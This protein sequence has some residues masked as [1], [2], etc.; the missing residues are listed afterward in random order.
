MAIKPPYPYVGGKRR[1]LNVI[2]ENIP[3]HFGNYYEPFLGAGA[4]AIHTME[5]YPDRHY[6]LS[7]YNPHIPPTWLALQHDIDEV[8]E[9]LRE[10][11]HRNSPH[12]FASVR[13]WDRYGMIGQMSTPEIAAR[14]IYICSTAN[15]GGYAMSNAGYSINSLG[16]ID[17]NIQEKNLRNLSALLNDRAVHVYR[18]DFTKVVEEVQAG[19][20]VYLDPPYVVEKVDDPDYSGDDS[21][22]KLESTE[23][24]VRKTYL[25]MDL[26]N[27]HGGY[28]LGSNSS[29]NLTNDL[30]NG[31]NKVETKLHWKGGRA[32]EKEPDT[33]VLWG[34]NALHRVLTQERKHLPGEEPVE[35]DQPKAPRKHRNTAE[36]AQDALPAPEP[37]EDATSP[38]E[39][40]QDEAAPN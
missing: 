38:S 26:V 22:I 1:L 9:L 18:K 19:D 32:V 25:F 2:A 40:K 11:Q 34:N 15:H 7:D 37:T 20:L 29:T 6:F 36:T 5:N 33:E 23:E 12:Y 28:A 35:E 39:S 13:N 30:W 24:V 27:T 4:V 31:W 10:H 8:I 3:P 17:W 21:Y 14:F 16:K